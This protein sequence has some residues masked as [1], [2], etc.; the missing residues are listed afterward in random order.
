MPL[1]KNI[2][3][4]IVGLP[5]PEKIDELTYRSAETELR[6]ADWHGLIAWSPDFLTITYDAFVKYTSNSSDR[7]EKYG[8]IILALNGGAH[9]APVIGYLGMNV[10]DEIEDKVK[11]IPINVLIARTELGAPFS[12]G[13]RF[14]GRSTTDKFSRQRFFSQKMEG[15]LV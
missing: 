1:P 12:Y 14:N 9:N 5:L 11:I 15:F 3:E 13:P 8:A 4:S 10:F 6:V 7:Y 2:P